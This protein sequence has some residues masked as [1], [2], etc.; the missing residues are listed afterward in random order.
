VVPAALGG[1]RVDK[2]VALLTGLARGDVARLVEQG[3]VRV[4]GRVVAVRSRR[5]AEGDELEVDVPEDAGAPGLAPDP[6]VAVA[7]VYADDD[8]AVVD[9]AAG[10]LVH[11]GAGRAGGTLAAGLVARWPELAG[12]GEPDRPGIVHRLDKGTSGLML[13]ARTLEAHRSLSAQLER[14]DVERRYLALVWGTVEAPAGLVDA[15]VGRA[16]RDPTR[17]SVSARGRQARTRYEVRERFD[18]PSAATLVE[19]RLETGRTH[20]IRVHLAAI[21]H[22]VLGDARY[23]GARSTALAP[24]PFLHAHRLAFDHPVSGERRSFTSELPA[25]LREVLGRFG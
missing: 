13:V 6:S 4:G 16:E 7:V 23:G 18:R 10:V 25:D 2:V 22:P 15:P 20:Q 17:M 21:G 11:P 8:V 9:K 14:R 1:E 19:C 24:R 12:V 3:A 5:L